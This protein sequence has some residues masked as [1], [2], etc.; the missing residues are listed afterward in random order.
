MPNPRKKGQGCFPEQSDK[1]GSCR[2]GR[3]QEGGSKVS[4][5]LMTEDTA[6]SFRSGST[7]GVEL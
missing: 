1:E 3:R 2:T 6:Q 7:R 5:E 4:S